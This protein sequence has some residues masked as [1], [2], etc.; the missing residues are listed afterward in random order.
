MQNAIENCNFLNRLKAL[1]RL[2]SDTDPEFPKALLFVAGQD[3]RCNRG[4]ITLIKYLFRGCVSKELFDE[5]LDADLEPLEDLIV[6]VKSNSLALILRLF[7]ML[8]A[9][10]CVVDFAWQS[11]DEKTVVSSVQRCAMSG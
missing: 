8:I 10:K 5:T 7:R 6:L 4:S 9:M 11:R 2:C 1:Q 3:G